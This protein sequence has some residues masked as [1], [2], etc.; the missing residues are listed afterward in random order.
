MK[1]FFSALLLALNLWAPSY[2]QDM[3]A[4]DEGTIVGRYRE[5]NCIGSFFSCAVSGGRLSF[6]GGLNQLTST[7]VALDDFLAGTD[8]SASNASVKFAVDRILAA[9]GY[10]VQGRLTTE[11]GVCNSTSDRTSQG[12]LYFTPCG[13]GN[14]I[15]LYDGTRWRLYTYTERSLSLTLTSDKNYDVFIYDNAGTLTLELSAAWTNDTT[16][17]DALTT[18]DGVTVKSGATTRRWLGVI[19]AS[20]SNVTEDS[21]QKRFVV[22][23]YNTEI[24]RNAKSDGTQHTYGTNS[25]R[26][27]NNTASTHRIG[28]LVPRAEEVF[29]VLLTVA[30]G[31]AGDG[32]IGRANASANL[33]SDTTGPQVTYSTDSSIASTSTASTTMRP[34]LGYHFLGISEI[35]PD[36]NSVTYFSYT[37]SLDRKI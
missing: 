37:V 16:R 24:R 4:R 22:N 29:I 7:D 30:A 3:T 11:S 27:W 36:S 31:N 20:G 6:T 15:T 12:T 19:R 10:P 32:S 14:A 2:A 28:F 26:A 8:T 1:K 21:E 18:Q 35:A 13:A 33:D 34:G 5:F 25:S 17:A 9:A 23:V